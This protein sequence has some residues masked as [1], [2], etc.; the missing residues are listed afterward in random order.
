LGVGLDLRVFVASAAC[1]VC[2]TEGARSQLPSQKN[3][4]P[5]N[6]IAVILS[7]GTVVRIRN[8]VVFRRQNESRLTLYI[9]T[10]TPSTEPASVALEAQEI[11]RLQ[12]KF[13]PREN[14]TSVSVGICRTQGCLEMRE[15]PEEMFWFVR[16]PDGSW[17]AEKQ[18]LGI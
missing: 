8:T 3:P 11:A 1:L 9:E 10:P 7:S 17:Q 16:Q 18:P 6:D 4:F 2:T 12:L 15:I 5:M 14:P 13:A